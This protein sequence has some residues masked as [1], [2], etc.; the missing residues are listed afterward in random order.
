MKPTLVILAAGLG[1]RYG[2]LKQVD[3]I[4]PSGESILDYSIYDAYR[5]GY[6]K[7][8]LVVRKDILHNFKNY[9]S[10]ISFPI[11][12]SCVIQPAASEINPERTKPWGTGHAIIAASNSI[13]GPFTVINADD[14]YGRQAFEKGVEILTNKN[15]DSN[16][17][18]GYPLAA[19]LSKFGAVSRAKCHVDSGFLASIDELPE[20]WEENE[21]IYSNQEGERIPLDPELIVSMNFWCF[22]KEALDTFQQTFDLFL[23]GSNL[24]LKAELLIP[25]VVQR[26][27][28]EGAKFRV[29]KTSA[30]W[31][32]VTYKEDK[33]NAVES[34]RQLIRE[35]EYPE[36][37]WM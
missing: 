2:G 4:G 13:D 29:E 5:A 35:G 23:Q 26:M 27:I 8:I 19:T 12:I 10:S 16:A 37:L 7:I 14:F 24:S 33:K 3:G 15:E 9:T 18:V 11:E 30:K 22:Q 21:R 34:I 20:I 6:K 28:E 36:K 25:H 1:S 32:G 17:L 31:F